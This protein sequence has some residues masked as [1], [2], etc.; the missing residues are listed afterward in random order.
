[1]G[2]LFMSEMNRIKQKLN[3]DTMAEEERKKMFQTFVNHGGKT[4]EEKE[5]APTPSKNR[6]KA[7]S[8]PV[9]RRNYS[10]SGGD[11][12]NKK[13][14]SDPSEQKKSFNHGLTKESILKTNKATL[15]TRF[16]TKIFSFMNKVTNFGGSFFHSNFINASTVDLLDCF[17]D[18]Q[19]VSIIVLQ[20]QSFEE[21]EIKNYFFKKFPY[22]Y[23]LLYRLQRL[24]LKEAIEQIR[25][26][27]NANS[28]IPVVSLEKEV[29]EIFKNLFV[30]LPYKKTILDA[31]AEGFK[32]LE[33]REKMTQNVIGTYLTKVKRDLGFIFEKYMLK[34]F[35]A[36][37]ITSGMTFKINDR[38]IP[39]FLDISERD[40]IGG[41]LSELGKDFEREEEAL[42]ED[43]K[44]SEEKTIDE[45]LQETEEKLALSAETQE[46]L[47]IID[48]IDFKIF[49]D[50]KDSPFYYYDRKDK[51]Y[52]IA[53]ILD[54]F[55]K[56][57][58]FIMT[59][60]K[61]R[62]YMEHH[63]GIKIDPKKDLNDQYMDIN[64][65]MDSIR[66]YS[67]QIKEMSGTEENNNIPI[68]QKHNLI[69]KASIQKSK[70]SMALRAKLAV[71]LEKVQ[72][73]LSKIRS[74][75]SKFLADPNQK[76]FFNDL[77]SKK[78][79]SGKSSKDAI[80]E[81]YA[82]I[83]AFHHFTTKGELGGAGNVV[84]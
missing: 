60:N 58:S 46:G 28:V 49:G 34:I 16:G 53:A 75:Y 82:F 71:T 2:G 23:E 11:S 79:L 15:L 66:E 13:N 26:K 24:K 36:F 74:D 3:I 44:S 69:H 67:S 18:L 5:E 57:Y 50:A 17:L 30:F 22:H 47:N 4:I 59:G 68:M 7:K 76:V 48:E 9:M 72:K 78:R 54:F 77:D 12:Q 19:R 65:V 21:F 35:Y 1:L 32:I 6:T 70:I 10:N 55:E 56:E 41:L 81:F 8:T 25:E 39:I 40:K 29:L 61:I 20:S 14:F 80:E 27:A 42:K 43:D 64:S 84:R 33:R 51:V 62:Y 83:C 38:A 73:T 63:E 45:K 37:L 31:F 52:R